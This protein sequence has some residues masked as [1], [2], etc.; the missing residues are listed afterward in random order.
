MPLLLLELLRW[1]GLLFR[2]LL[3]FFR[4][5]IGRHSQQGNHRLRIG[6]GLDLQGVL[7]LHD[8]GA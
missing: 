3:R 4:E 8:A 7:K 1:H 5:T 6:G 2:L